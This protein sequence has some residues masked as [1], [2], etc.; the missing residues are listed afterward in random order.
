MKKK[1]ATAK[2]GTVRS[3]K[4]ATKRAKKPTR[5][6]KKAA[7]KSQK[8]PSR[9]TPARKAPAQKAP[10]RK[11]PSQKASP[12]KA[13]KPKSEADQEYETTVA[14]FIA[15][16]A[17]EG[18]D[19]KPFAKCRT[20]F[21]VLNVLLQ[22]TDEVSVKEVLTDGLQFIQPKFDFTP[23]VESL[24]AA[25]KKNDEKSYDEIYEFAILKA[26]GA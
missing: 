14:P 9:S 20:F 19:T 4:N 16:L 26:M 10:S 23:Y 7:A 12:R 15:D 17:K 8:S 13:A 25:V 11:A 3:A 6:K 2:H 5:G 22:E 18:F 21:S 24:L 1:K